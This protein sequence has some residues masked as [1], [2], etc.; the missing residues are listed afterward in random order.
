MTLR[1]FDLGYARLVGY[2]GTKENST[3]YDT[4]FDKLKSIPN[5][6]WEKAVDQII[7]GEPRF[8]TIRIIK[9]IAY[10]LQTEAERGEARDPDL[11]PEK[12]EMNKELFPLFMKYLRKETPLEDWI[13][14][15]KY[16]AKKYGL[17]EKMRPGMEDLEHYLETG[18]LIVNSREL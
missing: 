15:M 8:P 11:L 1:E 3:R 7:E 17:T 4:W 13:L 12:V 2:F 16:Y 14:Q 5:T 6:A 18:E 9:S 10:G